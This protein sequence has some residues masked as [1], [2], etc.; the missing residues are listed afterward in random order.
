MTIRRVISGFQTGGDIAG[1]VAATRVGLQTG[2][3]MPKGFIT[4]RGPRPEF[5]ER[6]GAEESHS[7]SYLPRTKFNAQNSCVTILL[8]PRRS[9]SGTVKTIEYCKKASK[10]FL[11]V[12]PFTQCPTVAVEFLI[13]HTP[14]VVNIAGNRESICNGLSRRGA[15]YLEEVFRNI[16]LRESAT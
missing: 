10:P 9:S 5:A 4:E 13:R 8:S 7:T 3:Q 16:I 15:T 6:Y 14:E 12:N 11:I 1:I 2:G